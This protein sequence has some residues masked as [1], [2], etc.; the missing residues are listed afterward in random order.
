MKYTPKTDGI[1]H[2]N[3]YSKGQTELGRLLSNFAQTPFRI[4][5]MGNFESVEGFWYWYLTGAEKLRLLSGYN[6]K[7]YG[8]ACLKAQPT[9]HNRKESKF[10]K[11]VLRIAYRAKLQ[12]HHVI[13]E[14]LLENKL[15]LTHYYVF[16]S[17]ISV[18]KQFQWTAELWEEIKQERQ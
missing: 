8:Q 2:I 3:V 14:M 7:A 4:P 17:K 16:N 18:P 5:L 13:K 9:I 11:R 15:P 12:Y 6:A 10:P 1:D